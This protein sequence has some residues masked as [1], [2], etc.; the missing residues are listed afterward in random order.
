MPWKYPE[1]VVSFIAKNVKG[2]S[3]GELAALTN[4][5]FGTAFSESTMKNFKANHKLKSGLPTGHKAGTSIKYPENIKRFILEHYTGTGHQDMADLLNKIFGTGYTKEQMKGYYA[6]LKLNSGLTGRFQ[7]GNIPAN[8][9]THNG[10]W[11]P[12]QFKKGNIPHNYQP[13]GSERINTDG[14]H[15]IKIADPNKRKAKH[16]ILWEEQNGRVPKG[17]VL[18][19]GD[20]DKNNVC[21]DNLI[22]VS[23]RQLA[24]LNCHIKIRG[25]VELTKTAITMADLKSKINTRRKGGGQGE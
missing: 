7:K 25:S 20:G 11:E 8:K 17:H 3:T 4:A 2:K 9:G 14:Y 24:V 18:I 13:V 5:K 22:L 1:E 19:F 23:R 6:R 21:L 15:D 10:G 16:V 12:T